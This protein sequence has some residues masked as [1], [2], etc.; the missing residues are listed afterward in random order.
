MMTHKHLHSETR[1]I[2]LRQ[3]GIPPVTIFLLDLF[4]AP[5]LETLIR[6]QSNAFWKKQE[7]EKNTHKNTHTKPQQQQ[8]N[9]KPHTNT[10][11]KTFFFHFL[12]THY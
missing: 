3:T 2:I 4:V 9:N 10:N 8:T 12:G 7:K 1:Q 6:N 11:N 5:N